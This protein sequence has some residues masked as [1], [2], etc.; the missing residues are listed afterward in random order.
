[1]NENEN[2]EDEILASISYTKYK[3]DPDVLIDATMGEYNQKCG[4]AMVQIIEVLSK[5]SSIVHTINLVRDGLVASGHEELFIDILSKIGKIIIEQG[6]KLDGG[7]EERP[8]ISP[9]DMM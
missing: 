8:C 9:T 6:K 1:M 4:D 3:N 7:D 2:E 5:D